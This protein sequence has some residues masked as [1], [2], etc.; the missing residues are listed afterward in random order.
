MTKPGR[1]NARIDEELASKLEHIR[2]VTGAT[3]T[4]VVRESIELYYE[5]VRNSAAGP[6]KVLEQTGFLGCGSGPSNLSQSY[7]QLLADGLAGKHR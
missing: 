4:Q 3:T 6:R 5:A 7:K 1:L 2:R